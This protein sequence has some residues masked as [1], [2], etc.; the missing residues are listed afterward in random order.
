MEQVQDEGPSLFD[1]IF[2]TAE[3]QRPRRAAVYGTQG[4]GKTTFA[5][6]S[7]NPIIHPTEDGFRNVKAKAFPL[8]KTMG[9][10]FEGVYQLRHKPHDYKNYI[11]DT[12]DWFERLIWRSV[13]KKAKKAA[14]SDFDF[15]KGYGAA[16]EKFSEYLDM[17]SDLNVNRDMGIII[18]AHSKVVGFDD[19]ATE[20]YDRY[21][22]KLHD[23][24]AGLI[25]EWADEVFF[26]SH[27]V[28]VR[29]SGE[30]RDKRMRGI[31]GGGR[32]AYTTEK[33][34]HKAKNRLLG[35]PDE[36]PL[37]WSAYRAA[38]DEHLRRLSAGET[39]PA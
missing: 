15:G 3:A 11:L 28:I 5:T 16:A 6:G 22:P 32:V 23:Q 8:A 12:A 27:K 38:I 2:D 36:I 21:A 26:V 31:D 9:E 30:G 33:P 39:L 20:S 35:C 1:Q 34:A 19:P 29:E 17:V 24:I 14:I 7:E 18:L 25:Q 4:T 10:V 13:C 37:V